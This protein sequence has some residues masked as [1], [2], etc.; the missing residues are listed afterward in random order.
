MLIEEI[1]LS[2]LNLDYDSLITSHQEKYNDKELNYSIEDCC[3]IRTT[4]H[5]PFG[6]IIMTPENAYALYRDLPNGFDD[7]LRGLLDNKEDIK[8]FEIINRL[9]RN[10]VHFTI[11]GLVGNHINGDF[12]N[13]AFVILEPLKNHIN[14][15][16]LDTLRVEDT[17]FT[18]N[19]ELSNETVIVIKSDI[20]EI[21]KNDPLYADEIKGYKI[22]TYKGD[23]ETKAVSVVLN[24]L[25]YD[26][27]LVSAHGYVDSGNPRLPAD[28][29]DKFISKYAEEHSI[30]QERHFNSQNRYDAIEKQEESKAQITTKIID[31]MLETI[32][33]D[34]YDIDEL[35]KIAKYGC[36]YKEQRDYLA[37]FISEV[38]LDNLTGIINRV[39]EE[40]L[41]IIEEEKSTR[42]M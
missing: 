40:T 22:Y 8:R 23:D 39:N 21:I 2:G 7:A 28:M 27:F 9:R 26:S 20:Y 13:R 24:K 41:S 36:L 11:N 4:N 37:S 18:N 38:G 30:S 35:H 29:M 15:E 33:K 14:D 12:S 32:K 1:D 31:Y 25:G 19:I 17:Y 10:T 42:K 3:L 5:F 34:Q 16:H 6:R